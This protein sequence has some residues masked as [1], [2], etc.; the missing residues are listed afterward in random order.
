MIVRNGERQP[1]LV[2]GSIG[3]DTIETPF[4]VERDVLGGAASYAST[5]ASFFTKVR[6]VGVVGYDFPEEHMQFF[7][8]HGID[9]DGVQKVPGKTFRW[10]GYYEYDMNQAHTL[11]T[12][13]NVFE[14]FQPTIPAAYC[15]SAFVFLANIDPELQL[16][17]LDQVPARSFSLADTMNFWITSKREKVLEVVRRVDAITINDAEARQLCD[18]ASLVVAGRQLLAMGPRVVIIKKGEHGAVMFTESDYFVAPSFPLEDVLDPTGAGDTFAGGV[19]GYLAASNDLS[20]AN[21]RKAVLYG[22]VMASYSV[23]EFSLKRMARLEQGE[24]IMR[25]AEMRKI[26]AVTE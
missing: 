16:R 5:S 3:L 11:A 21:L 23:E 8:Q 18:T 13:L 12:H 22:S 25:Y 19:I 14:H 20:E 17:V 7:R 24:I 26:T 10:N 4:G 9:L 15:E 1:V 2:V 6:L